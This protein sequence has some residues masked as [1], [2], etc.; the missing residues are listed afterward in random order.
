MSFGG[1]D[2]MV[3]TKLWFSILMGEI[4]FSNANGYKSTGLESL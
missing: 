2:M 3:W 4:I 1:V